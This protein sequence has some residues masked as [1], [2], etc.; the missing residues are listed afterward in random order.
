[1]PRSVILQARGNP[2]VHIILRGSEN[3]P[4]YGFLA[5]PFTSTSQAYNPVSQSFFSMGFCVTQE[6]WQ[7]M[8]NQTESPKGCTDPPWVKSQTLIDTQCMVYLPTLTKKC[9][10][11]SQV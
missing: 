6:F 11:I 3:G 1:M 9:T 10:K 4:N 5:M 8:A 7:I 2:D